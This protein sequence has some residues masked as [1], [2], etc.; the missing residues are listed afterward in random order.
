M[1]ITYGVPTNLKL[2]EQGALR[3]QGLPLDSGGAKENAKRQRRKRMPQQ[4]F[5]VLPQPDQSA[6]ELINLIGN[7]L[8]RFHDIQCHGISTF[9][10]AINCKVYPESKVCSMLNGQEAVLS[11]GN[12]REQVRLFREL[13]LRWIY[14]E[15][16]SPV[17]RVTTPN[18]T[19]GQNLFQINKQYS[20]VTEESSYV[21]AAPFKNL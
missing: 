19:R 21:K 4:A 12:R 9:R 14:V 1:V 15:I 8:N 17:D 20:E 10:S 2:T 7:Q 18:G 11:L 5:L 3:F 6:A 13:G 16:S